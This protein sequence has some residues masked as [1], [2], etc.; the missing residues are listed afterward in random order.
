MS[1]QVRDINFWKVYN[2]FKGASKSSYIDS[3]LLRKFTYL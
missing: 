1:K 2:L 3:F